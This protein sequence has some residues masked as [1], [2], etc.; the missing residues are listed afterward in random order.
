MKLVQ[1]TFSKRQKSNYNKILLS[2]LFVFQLGLFP[3]LVFCAQ[4]WINFAVIM[5]LLIPFHAPNKQWESLLS[6][7]L[8]IFRYF[9]FALCCAKSTNVNRIFVELPMELWEVIMK[10][11]YAYLENIS[12]LDEF[13]EIE[14][15]YY[16]GQLILLRS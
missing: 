8:Q 12:N 5:A 14:N 1:I 6:W 7:K 16:V 13:H 4:S 10:G 9:N 15:R 2:I 3:E 11:Y